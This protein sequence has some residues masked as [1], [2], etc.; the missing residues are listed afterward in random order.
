MEQVRASVIKQVKIGNRT[1]DIVKSNHFIE[2]YTTAKFNFDTVVKSAEKALDKL[3]SL[4]NKKGHIEGVIKYRDLNIVFAVENDMHTQNINL[5]LQTAK[6]KKNFYLL[7][8]SDV[9]MRVK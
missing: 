1:V 6:E 9:E 7:N 8:T 2:R 3:V 4:F 5:V